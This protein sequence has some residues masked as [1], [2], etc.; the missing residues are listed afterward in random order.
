[1]PIESTRQFVLQAV[2]MTEFLEPRVLIPAHY[3]S[4]EYKQAF[5]K[6]LNESWTKRGKP[7]HI[8]HMKTADY[9]Y[10]KN[11]E[12]GMLILDMSP[13]A[14]HEPKERRKGK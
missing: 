8:E 6:A 4:E 12:E 10:R 9:I 3:W 13:S 2:R 11:R 7:F 1:M 5:L 14:R